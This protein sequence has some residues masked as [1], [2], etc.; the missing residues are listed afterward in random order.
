M[1]ETMI[2]AIIREMIEAIEADMREEKTEMK[3]TTT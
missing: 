2:S 1:G 3:N